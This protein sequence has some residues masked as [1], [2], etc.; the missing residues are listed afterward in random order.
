M[1]VCSMN[2]IQTCYIHYVVIAMLLMGVSCVA[3]LL[4]TKLLMW[5]HGIVKSPLDAPF[6]ISLDSKSSGYFSPAVF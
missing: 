2:E 3:S 4:F 6:R 1:I 5:P